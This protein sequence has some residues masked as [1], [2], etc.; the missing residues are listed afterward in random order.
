MLNPSLHRLLASA[1]A[2][3]LRRDA[4]S[5]RLG[6]PVRVPLRA[7]RRARLDARS[8]AAAAVYSDAR[9][10][11]IRYAYPDDRVALMRLAQLDSAEPGR[12]PL[13]V[14]EVEGELWAALSLA[15]GRVI[16]DPFRRTAAMVE[17][18]RARAAQL[19]AAAG[20]DRGRSRSGPDLGRR[21]AEADA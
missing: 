19:R 2:D 15:D 16:A 9:T 10:I 14:A 21:Y 11:T 20:G 6:A 3:D 18:L 13:L 4:E 7:R 8:R 12:Q 5:A 1:R 17:L